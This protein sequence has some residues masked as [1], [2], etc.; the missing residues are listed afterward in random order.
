[1]HRG[2]IIT[3]DAAQGREYNIV[4]ISLVRCNSTGSLGFLPDLHRTCVMLSRA[5]HVMCIVGS[6]QTVRRAL[7]AGKWGEVLSQCESL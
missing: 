7:K 3:A 2:R 5:R 4:V 1:M 6:K